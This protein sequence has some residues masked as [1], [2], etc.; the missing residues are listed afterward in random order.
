L[1]LH[2]DTVERS[3]PRQKPV[4]KTQQRRHHKEEQEE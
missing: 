3:I 1:L 2:P 4:V